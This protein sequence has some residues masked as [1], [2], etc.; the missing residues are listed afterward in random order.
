MMLLPMLIF[1]RMPVYAAALFWPTESK[2]MSRSIITPARREAM[3]IAQACSRDKR[4]AAMLS[5][6]RRSDRAE[7]VDPDP[8]H[9]ADS[10]DASVSREAVLT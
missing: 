8:E 7:L 2:Q 10:H 4:R 1:A 3:E 9:D 6:L 5:D